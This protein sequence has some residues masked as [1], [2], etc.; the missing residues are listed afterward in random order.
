MWKNILLAIVVSLSVLGKLSAQ[1]NDP[2]KITVP[3][4]PYS[5]D[6]AI[7]FK[8]DAS[9]LDYHLALHFST[10]AQNHFVITRTN[11]SCHCVDTI[12]TIDCLL[13]HHWYNDEEIEIVKFMD[14]NMDGFDDLFV[15]DGIPDI[16]GYPSYNVW[17]FDPKTGGYFLNEEFSEHISPE[18]D[19]DEAKKIIKT[20]KLFYFRDPFEYSYYTYKVLGNHLILI[21]S[22]TQSFEK[23]QVIDDS[24]RHL[25][26]E[27]Q[28][29]VHGKLVVVERKRKNWERVLKENDD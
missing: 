29:L 7:A 12:A 4:V 21:E 18:C 25:I 23:D 28:K 5:L 26:W 20:D 16:A 22:I 27:H 15:L 13:D 9:F 2:L 19:F 8:P 3:D 10:D 11:D 6:T 1:L 14:V 24:E 17:L